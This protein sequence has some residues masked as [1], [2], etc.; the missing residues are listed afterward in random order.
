MSYI[1]KKYRNKISEIFEDLSNIDNDILEL[2]NY[3]SIK[4][5]DKIAKLCA[6]CNKSVNQILKVF[7]PE[8]KNMNDKLDIKS[9]L[10]FYYDLIDKLTDYI[11]NV[12]NFQKLDDKYYNALINFIK[13]KD[14]LISGK[15]RQICTNELTAFYDPSTRETLEKILTEK[16]EKKSREY[17]AMGPL[18]QEIKKIGKIAGADIVSILMVE[19][20]HIRE[21][22]IIENPRTVIHYSVFSQDEEKLKSIGKE[23]KQYLNSKGYE[24]AILL[25]ELTDLIT[26]REALTGSII[27]DADLL[28]DNR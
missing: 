11:R 15:Y 23:L 22:K 7:Y 9:T 4:Y 5:A 24:A 28:A 19:D 3:R 25:V 26:E 17:F 18:E 8:I 1:E 2:L 14:L 13:E 12:E 16:I 20:M 10:K 6:L 27:T 21:F